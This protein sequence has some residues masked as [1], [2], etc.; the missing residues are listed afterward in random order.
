MAN[1][2][3]IANDLY[4]ALLYSEVLQDEGHTVFVAFSCQ[5]ALK[6]ALKVALHENIDVIILDEKLPDFEVEKLL[7]R[8]KW[9]QP[10]LRSILVADSHDGLVGKAR[11]WDQMW[12]EIFFKTCDLTILQAKVRRLWHEPADAAPKLSFSKPRQ[13]LA[14]RSIP[15]GQP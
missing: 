9:L 10:D 6:L 14:L 4:I 2:L 8:L 15:A 5:G 11:L 13:Q 12:D 3:T 1:I 7:A